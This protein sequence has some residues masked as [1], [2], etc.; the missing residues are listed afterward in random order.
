VSALTRAHTHLQVRSAVRENTLWALVQLCTHPISRAHH[1][2]LKLVAALRCVCLTDENVC[3]IGFAM[4]AL[5]RLQLRS[6]VGAEARGALAAAHAQ[7]AVRCPETLART[8]PPGFRLDAPELWPQLHSGPPSSAS[9]PPP[10]FAAASGTDG[11]WLS[12][13]VRV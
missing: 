3:S 8:S 1:H 7:L 10:Q 2:G 6:E 5:H 11:R 12:G 13:G 9:P 4:D